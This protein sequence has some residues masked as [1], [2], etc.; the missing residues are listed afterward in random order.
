[1]ELDEAEPGDT[2][3]H[4]TEQFADPYS[5]DIPQT[6]DVCE[7][8]G[9]GKGVN[10]Y[11]G[12]NDRFSN[13]LASIP[14]KHSSKR[15]KNRLSGPGMFFRSGHRRTGASVTAEERIDCGSSRIMLQGP[16]ALTT[17]SRL[18]PIFSCA[19]CTVSKPVMSGHFRR[20]A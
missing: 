9:G 8:W 19:G 17:Q 6:L 11:D 18:I 12:W 15:L 5:W 10:V 14:S 1:M 13:R 3:Q 4:V 7:P 2:R 20:A 16:Q